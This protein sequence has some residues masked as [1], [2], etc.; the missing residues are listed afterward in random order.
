MRIRLARGARAEAAEAQ[1]YYAAISSELGRGFSD[2]MAS[3]VE[4]ITRDPLL[5]PPLTKRIRR[6]L[7]DRFPYAL[8][9]R[10]DAEELVVL[11]VMHQR[12]KPGYWHRR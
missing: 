10:V 3:A 9:Y 7:F 2:A 6:C 8:I 1:R 5:W 4:R 11:T 12:R